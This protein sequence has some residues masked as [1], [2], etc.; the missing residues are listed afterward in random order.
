MENIKLSKKQL[1]IFLKKEIINLLY[2]DK[3]LIKNNDNSFDNL[4]IEDSKIESLIIDNLKCKNVIFRNCIIKKGEIKNLKC[5]RIDFIDCTINTELKF[6]KNKLNV[7]NI[8]GFKSNK[9]KFVDLDISLLNLIKIKCDDI[10]ID[11][12]TQSKIQKFF[13]KNSDIFSNIYIKNVTLEE[14]VIDNVNTKDFL[15]NNIIFNNGKIS[16]LESKIDLISID[17]IYSEILNFK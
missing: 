15:L 11:H 17:K 1:P 3:V 14:C 2:L 5:D 6:F 9:I 10:E 12:V 4:I 8:E 16:I 7:I 13:F